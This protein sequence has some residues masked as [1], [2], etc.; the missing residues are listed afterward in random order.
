MIISIIIITIIII[1]ILIVLILLIIIILPSV[2]LRS[3]YRTGMARC[4]RRRNS[5]GSVGSVVL[6][7]AAG[8]VRLCLCLQ[9]IAKAVSAYTRQLSWSSALMH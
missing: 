6:L 5:E 2:L 3:V 9:L 4:P 7:H 1:L 8:D